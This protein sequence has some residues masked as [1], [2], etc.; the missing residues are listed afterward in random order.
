MRTSALQ[1]VSVCLIILASV[2]L[3]APVASESDY[4][5]E[6]VNSISTPKETIEIEGT[7]Y[8]VDGVGVIKPG[9]PIEIEV[10]SQEQYSIYLYNTDEKAEFSNV[11]TADKTRVAMGTEDDALDTSTL[12]P[13]TYM[14]SLEPRGQGR[15]A[16]YPV[17]VEE[18]DLSVDHPTSAT[19][20]EE[21][22]ITA[23]IESTDAAT[24]VD[25]V[26]VAIWNEANDDGKNITLGAE[27]DGTYSTTTNLS[28]FGEG[29]Y[30]VYGA[31]QGDEEAQGYPTI[32]AID[33]GETLTV[34]A[35]D[36][37][38]DDGTGS[39]G[40]SS[41]GGGGGGGSGGVAS[42]DDSVSED[43]TN[44][45]NSSTDQSNESVDD[46]SVTEDSSN[47][48]ETDTN[49]T[50]V[51]G[52]DTESVNE[53]NSDNESTQET[54][55]QDQ[56]LNPNNESETSDESTNTETDSVGTPGFFPVVTVFALL[57]VGYRQT[58]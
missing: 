14:L 17:V 15:Q 47:E 44:S 23:S 2:S 45:S 1:V 42:P 57:I 20:N 6:V 19:V 52:S 29:E 25:T 12:E 39:G 26:D 10:T 33:N 8:P 27:G 37:E 48:S 56:V 5:L 36:T 16:V 34:T 50:S 54:P 31:V 53:T 18:F 7:E 3:A 4:D 38:E 58:R 32:V 35:D 55:G 11:W 41:G 46:D 24:N 49:E 30:H 51:S 28:D 40:G 9:E 43:D 13:G 22:N 21:I